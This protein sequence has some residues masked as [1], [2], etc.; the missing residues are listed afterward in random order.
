MAQRRTAPADD[1]LTRVAGLVDDGTLGV[2][3]AIA[4]LLHL[5][6]AGN[7]TTTALI[8]NAV[9]SLL[10][11]PEQLEVLSASPDLLG[12]CIEETLRFE[13]PLPRDRR[14]AVRDVCLGD[15]DIR[16]GERVAAVL[17]AANRDPGHFIDPDVYDIARSFTTSHHASFGRGIHF[18][19]GAPV[20][21]LEAA[22]ALSAVL[23]RC[24]RPRLAP[25][26][27]PDW[28]TITTHHGLTTLPIETTR[29]AA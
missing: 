19:L 17:A 23:E 15:V 18:C 24:P 11:H 27:A 2:D 25:G 14:I 21:R 29:S 26:F 28:H 1:V 20:A 10:D 7:S 13:A 16:A 8:G 4:T 22:V 9:Y 6:I 5:V 12:N 3:E